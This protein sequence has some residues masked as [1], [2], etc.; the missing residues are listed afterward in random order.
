[1]PP[2]PLSR[3]ER[4]LYGLRYRFAALRSWVRRLVRWLFSRGV[5]E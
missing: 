1:L 5:K 2:A 4:A 3:W